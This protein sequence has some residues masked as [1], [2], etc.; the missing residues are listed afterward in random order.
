MSN[1]CVP[2]LSCTH[3]F[4]LDIS[5]PMQIIINLVE[6]LLHRM[7]TS[8]VHYPITLLYCTCMSCFY[9][10]TYIINVIFLIYFQLDTFPPSWTED[11]HYKLY[12]IQYPSYLDVDDWQDVFKPCATQRVFLPVSQPP[13]RVPC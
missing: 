11:F 12:P 9:G 13:H 6:K 10:R 1:Y 7:G 5:I 2:C 8:S 3:L 4:F